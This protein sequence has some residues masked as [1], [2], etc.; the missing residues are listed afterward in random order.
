M[1][2]FDETAVI[3][4]ENEIIELS[5]TGSLFPVFEEGNHFAGVS[6][7]S[8]ESWQV[9]NHVAFF[10]GP[11]TVYAWDRN[12]FLPIG[13]PIEKLLLPYL[14]PS[15]MRSMQSIILPARGEYHL[16]LSGGA[17][18]GDSESI[19]LVFDINEG[20]WFHDTMP[21]CR[22]I[23][24]VLSV[25]QEN[26]YFLGSDNF[27]R[28]F[29]LRAD[30]VD[31]IGVEEGTS[32]TPVGRFD[33][34]DFLPLNSKGEPTINGKNTFLALYFHSTPSSTIT[35]GVSV[36]KGVTFTTRTVTVDVNGVGAYFETIAFSLIRFTFRGLGARLSVS[37]PLEFD[38]ELSGE[39]N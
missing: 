27:S 35:V 21:S 1:T 11:D 9:F 36:D 18:E 25:K 39:V 30:G 37:G 31:L 5:P 6:V 22:S 38:Y 10:L 26:G 16:L 28:E 33:T 19:L 15:R 7:Y 34:Q 29:S 4:L 20:R 23:G 13:R 14:H 32:L 12:R 8:P 2:H 24:R 3:S 17:S